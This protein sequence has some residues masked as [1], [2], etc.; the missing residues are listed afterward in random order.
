[1]TELMTNIVTFH[2]RLTLNDNLCRVLQPEHIYEIILNEKRS[3][4]GT[5]IRTPTGRVRVCSPTIRRSPSIV[6][7]SRIK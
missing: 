2:I 4:W 1:M 5:G 7:W 3:G 6:E